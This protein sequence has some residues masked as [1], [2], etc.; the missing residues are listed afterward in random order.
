LTREYQAAEALGLDPRTLY[1]S[2]LAGVLCD[3]ETKERLRAVGESF[4][5]RSIAAGA[6]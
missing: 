3:G 2:A 1:E 5:W 4:A 6:R